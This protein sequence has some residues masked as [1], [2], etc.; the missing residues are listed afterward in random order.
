MSPSSP[1]PS[2]ADLDVSALQSVAEG[3]ESG[4]VKGCCA[5]VYEQPAVRWLLGGELHPGGEDLTRRMFE[6]AGIGPDDRVLDVA[7]G[8]GTTAMLAARELGC[9]VVGLEYGAVAVAGAIAEAEAAGLGERVSFVQGDAEALPFEAG[10]FDVVICECALCTFPDKATA[11]AEMRR[12]LGPGGRLALSDVIADHSRLPE[13][14]SGTM[15]TVACVGAAL[16]EQGYLD[17]LAA[18]GFESG[19]VERATDDVMR[20]TEGVRTRLRGA[21]ILGFEDLVPIDGGLKHAIKLAGDAKAAIRDGALDYA[22]FTA[23]LP[24]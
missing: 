1:L 10:S 16:P 4:D 6:L 7:S 13:D 15:A 8:A 22:V 9:E 3:L 19:Q 2:P 14:L 21:K 18:A 12:V 20:L 11:M 24:S 5:T 17:L 23:R